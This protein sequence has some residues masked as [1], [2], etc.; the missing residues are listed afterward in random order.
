MNGF[1]I[2]EELVDTGKARNYGLELTFEKF[3]SNQYYFL[4]TFSMYDSK[5]KAADNNWYDSRY[6]FN[7]TFN[8][9]GG[10]EFTVG[11][12]NNNTI[13]INAKILLNGGKR[14]TPYDIENFNSTGDIRFIERERNTLQFKDYARL[15]ASFYYRLNRS[16]V[17]HVISLDIQ[18]I[19][20]RENVDSQ[21]F[22]PNTQTV[23]NNYQLSLIPFLNYRIEF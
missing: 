1:F 13:G 16:K 3:F 20:N 6:N 2:D 4:S 22:N 23:G 8:L 7:Y 5:Y 17:S 10:K 15:D 21:F 18:N 12:T 14:G 9:V 11:K 19:T